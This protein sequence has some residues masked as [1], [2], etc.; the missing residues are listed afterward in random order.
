MKF[1]PI[2]RTLCATVVVALST[3]AAPAHAQRADPSAASA[4]SLLPVAIV[5]AAPAALLSAGAT[6][7]VVA[8]ESSVRGSVWVLERASDGAR[9]S[10]ELAGGA[11]VALGS[12]VVVGAVA[13]G[14]ILSAAGQMIAFV[15]NEIGSALLY[16]ERV[17]R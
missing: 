14:W 3:A 2:V 4:L 9:A 12:A 16:H 17:S 13:S 7:T 5:V 11:S 1:K 6:L 15:P 10:I 8:V